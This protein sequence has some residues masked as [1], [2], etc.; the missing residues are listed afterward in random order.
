MPELISPAADGSISDADAAKV[1]AAAKS[2]RIA[3]FPTET[4]YALGSTGLVKAATRRLLQIKERSTLK[5]LPVLVASVADAKRWV[6]W[7]PLAERLAAKLWPGPVYLLLKPT[8]EGRLL[9]FPEYP[10]LAVRVPAHPVARAIVA[11]SGVPWVC[12]SANKSG[13]PPLTDAS[14]VASELGAE[15]DAIVGGTAGVGEPTFVDAAG[16]NARATK[17]GVVSAEAVAEAAR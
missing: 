7:T 15:I 11:A 12:T 9:T 8:A 10:N 4:A 5:P 17:I 16:E 13:R 1:G 3:A 6:E 14:A 2:C